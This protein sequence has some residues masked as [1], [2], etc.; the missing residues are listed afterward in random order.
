MN[1]Q[2]NSPFPEEREEII[3]NFLHNQGSIRIGDVID[4][5]NISPSTAR[6]LLQKMQDKGMLKRTH[7]GA[8]L[9]G[10]ETSLRN[11]PR[12]FI[13]IGNREAKLKIASAAAATVENGDYICLGSG[14]TTF[15][16]ATL[17]HGIQDLTV[18][19]DS[20]PIANELLYDEAI[21][22]YVCGGWIL[23]RNNACRGLT[24]ENF[25]RD[26]RVDKVYSGA[27]SIDIEL[28]ITSVD[29]DPRTESA[30][31]HSG[32][33]CYILADSTKFKIRPYMDK[34][35]KIS[36]ID[37]VVTDEGI[38]KKYV[39]ALENADVKVIIG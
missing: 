31:C 15:L 21:T 38:D 30:I 9:I 28:G 16:M 27:D 24:A 14:T 23:K 11:A 36:D 10:E 26:I 5:L 33:Q 3:M 19:T 17:L 8:I 29:F 39:K 18:V 6:L 25:F 22:L 4:I 2:N 32:K 1:T 7:G 20:I 34:V 13:N 12:D 37:Y 35:V